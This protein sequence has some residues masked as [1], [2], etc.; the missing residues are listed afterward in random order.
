MN[1]I[2][3]KDWGFHVPYGS[4]L[5]AGP[6]S[7]ETEEQMLQTTLQLS[8]LPV[9]MLRA[10][11]WK[12]R[13]RPNAFEGIGEKGLPWLKLAGRTSGLPVCVEV[14]SPE[15]VELALKYGIDALW[16]GARSTA[17]PFT[18]Q[19]I[20]DALKGTDIPVFVKNPVNP[21]LQLWL[22]AIERIYNAGIN[23]IAAIHRGFS[24]YGQHRYRNFPQWEIPIEL[25]RLLPNIEI[26]C[27]PSHI[28]GKRDM[29]FEI[30][31][32]AM[33]LGFE[34]LMIESHYSPDNA[35]SDAAQQITPAEL[36]QILEKLLKPDLSSSD[37][38]FRSKLENLRNKID[39]IDF[40]I[41]D[42]LSQRMGLVREIG[43]YKKE[44]NITVLQIERWTEIFKSRM[45]KAEKMGT[46]PAF[47]ES[48][49]N[50]IHQESIRQQTEIINA[51]NSEKIKKNI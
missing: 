12:P 47:I 28:G 50:A 39:Q 38:I 27:D 20:A 33:N 2:N 36:D 46:A 7:A 18:V 49:I 29:I 23:R 11:I 44:N 5:I 14:A 40:K 22:G 34:G 32:H 17:N 21:D 26:L 41:L 43:A 3:I 4:Y 1:I 13:T 37:P 9:F 30:S 19:A 8:N 42:L 15:H 31:Q 6:C 10:G 16:I 24:V 35:W 48:L 45:E 51:E 25:R